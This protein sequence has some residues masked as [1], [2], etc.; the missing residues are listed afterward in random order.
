MSMAMALLAG[1]LFGLGLIFSGMSN[2]ANVLGFLDLAGAWNPSLAFVLGGAVM[3]G[4]LGFSLASRRS[5]SILGDAMRIPTNRKIDLRLVVGSLIFGVGWG[6]AGYCPG[7]VLASLGSAGIKP[8]LFM[9]AMLMG[10]QLF[11]ILERMKNR[12]LDRV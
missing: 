8:F 9:I 11:E 5:K 3:I 7:A 6:L 2:P 1:L 10:M 4:M 12:L